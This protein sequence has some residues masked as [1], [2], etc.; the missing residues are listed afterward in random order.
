ME[1]ILEGPIISNV[2][3][4]ISEHEGGDQGYAGGHDPEKTAVVCCVAMPAPSTST[5]IVGRRQETSLPSNTGAYT[6]EPVDQRS[7]DLS[8]SNQKDSSC[9]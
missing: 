7:L 6:Y 5:I 2:F 9:R 4:R 8:K 1:H 3:E